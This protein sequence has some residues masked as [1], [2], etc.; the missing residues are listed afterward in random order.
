MRYIKDP[1]ARLEVT[2]KWARWLKKGSR[3]LASVTYTLTKTSGT[4]AVPVTNAGTALATP[5]SS[6]TL[7]GGSAGDNWDLTAHG[8]DNTNQIEDKTVQIRVRPK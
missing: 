6:V 8:T 2:F 1:D 7:A 4:G 5:D 3:T